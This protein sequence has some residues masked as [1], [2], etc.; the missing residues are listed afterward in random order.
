[1]EI[2]DFTRRSRS[3]FALLFSSW[4]AFVALATHPDAAQAVPSMARQTGQACAACHT[5]FPE[6]TP[7]GRQFKLQAFALSAG[8]KPKDSMF[9]DVP[10]S[11]VVQFSRT[12]TK[13]VSTDG[14]TADDFPQDRKSILQLAG[15]YYGGKITDNSGALIQYNYDGIEKEVKTE[16]FDLRWASQFSGAG[17]DLLFGATLSNSPTVTDIYNSTPNW[18]FPHAETAAVMPNAATMVDMTLASKVGGPGVYALWNQLVYGEFAIYR[19][20][21]NGILRPLGWGNERS[22]LVKGNAPYW[23]LAVQKEMGEHSFAVG[24]Y[25]LN[26]QTYI[27]PEDTSSPSDRFRDFG[28]DGQYQWT[29]ETHQFS[30]HATS[31]REKQDLGA[32]MDAGLASNSSSNL[33]TFR[34]D[35]HYFFRRKYGGGIQYFRTTGDSDDLRYNTGAPLMGSV[36]GSPNNKGWMYSLAYLPV[37]NVKLEA[38]YTMYKEFNGASSNY[39]GFGRNA[40]DNNSLYLLAWLMF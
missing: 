7:F 21:R 32:S 6:L 36:N 40:S 24:T 1:M 38:R 13:N 34:A 9:G 15:V 5:V 4:L 16:M 8:D 23:R 25:G 37:Q 31:I 29:N 19:N 14:T 18:S 3:A 10:I 30:A 12:A 20:N 22:P 17:Q 35:A 26:V 27:D 28:L 33:R 39:D 11:M 2:F